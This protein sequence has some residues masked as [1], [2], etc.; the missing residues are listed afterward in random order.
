MKVGIYIDW[1]EHKAASEA[2]F[3]KVLAE[4]AEEIIADEDELSNWLDEHYSTAEVF[5]FTEEEK[6]EVWKKWGEFANDVA[7]EDLT[8]YN[9]SW[10]YEILEV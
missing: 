6:A 9:G 5:N 1:S 3:Q 2:E 4:K 8:G 7:E 10:T